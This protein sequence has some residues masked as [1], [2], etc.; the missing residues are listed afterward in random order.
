MIGHEPIWHAERD[1]ED[2]VLYY[3]NHLVFIDQL[4][5][6][7]PSNSSCSSAWRERNP[8]PIRQY[9]VLQQHSRPDECR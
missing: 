3:A 8:M 1:D 5:A 7:A 4:D 2:V 9:A 6:L